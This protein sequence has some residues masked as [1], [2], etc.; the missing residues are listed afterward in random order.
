MVNIARA[1]ATESTTTKP[2]MGEDCYA[3]DSQVCPPAKEVRRLTVGDLQ[4][5]F[6]VLLCHRAEDRDRAHTMMAL[7]GWEAMSGALRAL[8][9]VAKARAEGKRRV[10]LSE[11][12][13]LLDQKY[14]LDPEDYR[15]AGLPVPEASHASA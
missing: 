11:L 4:A 1:R 15:R 12:A 8:E 9:P 13:E 6:P 14:V 3:N 7:Y 5:A 2:P 10:L